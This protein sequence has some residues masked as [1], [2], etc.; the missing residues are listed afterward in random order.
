MEKESLNRRNN[1]YHM[2][3]LRLERKRKFKKQEY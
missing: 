3:N 1:R 2:S